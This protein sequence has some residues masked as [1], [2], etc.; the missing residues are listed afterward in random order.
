MQK[1]EFP[2]ILKYLLAPL[3]FLTVA[4]L[5]GLRLAVETNDLRFIAPQLITLILAAFAI[6]LF[7]RGGLLEIA[8]R[9]GERLGLLDNLAGAIFL[10]SLY[11]ATAQVF[12]LVT[13]ERGL[14]NFCFNLFYLL[15]FFNNLFVLFNPQRLVKS[16]AMVLGASF[17]L[18]YLV[19]ADLFSPTESWSKYMLQKLLQTASLGALEFE[20]FAPLT[21]YLAFATLSLYLIGL[22]LIAPR[23][24]PGE[25]LLY[26]IFVDRYKLRP[27]ERKH[28]MAALAEATAEEESEIIEAEIMNSR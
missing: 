17:A 16:L 18:K 8:G 15:I 27:Q 11:F 3:G 9:V 2:D 12:N 24:E 5:G 6:I 4:L 7:V 19:F 20:V 26:K 1:P 25:E 23:I 22:Y 10:L 13:P 14:L 28:L 21:G